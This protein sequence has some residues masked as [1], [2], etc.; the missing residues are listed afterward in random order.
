MELLEVMKS[1]FESISTAKS[2][3]DCL[4]SPQNVMNSLC[5]DYFLLVGH[6]TR[7]D[8]GQKAL[9]KAGIFKM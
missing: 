2:A 1:E 3:H 8:D 7:S 4:L 9:E 5:Q 6:L